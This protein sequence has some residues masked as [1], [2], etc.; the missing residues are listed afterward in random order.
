MCVRLRNSACVF[1]RERRHGALDAFTWVSPLYACYD[2]YSCLL[3]YAVFIVANS[4]LPTLRAI[5]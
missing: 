3:H 5:I 2:C 4:T 1:D